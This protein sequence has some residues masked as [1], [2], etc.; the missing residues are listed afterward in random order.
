MRRILLMNTRRR[1]AEKYGGAYQRIKLESAL[2]VG[3][4]RQQ[5]LEELDE[6]LTRLQERHPDQAKLIKLCHILLVHDTCRRRLHSVVSDTIQ[7]SRRKDYCGPSNTK[8]AQ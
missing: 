4:D 3:N 5:R 7:V 6:A 1:R 2:L 8:G